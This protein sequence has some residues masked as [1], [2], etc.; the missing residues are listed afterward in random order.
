MTKEIGQAREIA[1]QAPSKDTE[2]RWKEDTTNPPAGRASTSS[3]RCRSNRSPLP[4]DGH[5]TR[6]G[7]FRQEKGMPGGL[8]RPTRSDAGKVTAVEASG[9][10]EPERAEDP[11]RRIRPEDSGK[12]AASPNRGMVTSVEERRGMVAPERAA[13]QKRLTRPENGDERP[14][15]RMIGEKNTTNPPVGRHIHLEPT[16]PEQQVPTA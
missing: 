10:A 4:S 1:Q 16:L 8:R 3:P 12:R 14:V 2:W 11:K 13:C 6:Y 5:L 15:L 7:T 9:K